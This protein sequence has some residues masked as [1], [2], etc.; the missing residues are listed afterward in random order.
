[1][2]VTDVVGGLD[3]I[4][5]TNLGFEQTAG[6]WSSTTNGAI[7]IVLM[8]RCQV[9]S[10]P[11]VVYNIKESHWIQTALTVTHDL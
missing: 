4:W 1:M 6:P 7:L 11:A 3:K 10:V 9:N 2:M 8:N 5:N